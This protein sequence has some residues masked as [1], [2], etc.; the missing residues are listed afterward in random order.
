[1]DGASGDTPVVVVAV[2][3]MHPV[4]RMMPTLQCSADEGAS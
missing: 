4:H 1:M 3:T 2:R